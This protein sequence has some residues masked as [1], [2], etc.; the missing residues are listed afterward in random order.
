[1]KVFGEHVVQAQGINGFVDYLGGAVYRGLDLD[2]KGVSAKISAK[3]ALTIAKQHNDSSSEN[4]LAKDEVIYRNEKSDYQIF[5]DADSKAH[6]AFVVN[7]VKDSRAGGKPSRPFVIVDAVSGEILDQWEGLNHADATGPGGNTK[8]GKYFY[9]QEFG[10]LKVSDDCTMEN[11]KVITVNLNHGTVGTTPYKFSCPTNT[12][13]EI[14]GAFSPINDAHFFGG[15]VFDLYKQWYNTTPIKQ[16][17]S[18]RI[19]YSTNYENAF[20]DGSA[21]TF[22]DGGTT[23]FP[24]VSLDVSA[25]EVSHGFTEQNSALEYKGQSGGINES[26]SDM[27][28]EAAEYFMHGTNDFQVGAQIFKAAN[29]SLRFMN[30]PPLDGQSIGDASDYYDG[31]DVHFSSG[32][33]NKAFYLL[34]TKATWNTKKAFDV[35]VQANRAYWTPK[36]SFNKGACGVEKGAADLGYTVADVTDAFAQVGVTCVDNDPPTPGYAASTVGTSD[37]V[38][39]FTDTSTD[40]DGTVVEWAWDFG[41]EAT[42]TEKSPTH[43]FAAYGNYQVQLTVKDDKGTFAKIVKKIEVKEIQYSELKNGVAFTGLAGAS[44][45]ATNFWVTVPEGAKRFIITMAGGTGD[46]DMY[47]KYN[48]AA[49]R[50]SYDYRPYRAG[51]NEEVDLMNGEIKPGTYFVLLVGYKAYAGVTLKATFE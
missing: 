40:T 32:V 8:T 20:W 28:G 46:A 48:A 15:V 35:F 2:L 23:F 18:M 22:G 19:H 11:D 38:F 33:Y 47:V 24:M 36:T 29:Q 49:T 7:F 50:T 45:S 13:K 41:D 3:K 42:S 25:H 10:P 37:K 34:A 26:F 31:L 14:N 51:N 16:K 1:L 27:A 17:L 21:M 44:G 5:V 30:D 9:G 43:E 6:Y 12:F 39:S 4:S